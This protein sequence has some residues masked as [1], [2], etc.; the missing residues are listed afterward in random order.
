MT[1]NKTAAATTYSAR[2]IL[3]AAKLARIEAGLQ[4][5]ASRQ[6]QQPGDWGY[7]GTLERVVELL[8]Q[9]EE[10]LGVEEKRRDE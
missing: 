6:E 8:A 2:Q 5:H 10:V 1:T 7:A 9:V 3:I 4:Q